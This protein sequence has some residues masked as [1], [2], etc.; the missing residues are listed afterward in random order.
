[1]ITVLATKLH[2]QHEQCRHD[3]CQTLWSF[4]ALISE[5]DTR[6][7]RTLKD[8]P[9]AHSFQMMDSHAR[10]AGL[11]RLHGAVHILRYAYTHLLVGMEAE[12][13]NK[14]SLH[15]Q[16]GVQDAHAAHG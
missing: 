6:T 14:G 5:R 9:S 3:D 15:D 10:I 4:G 16:V 8:R 13:R 2:L 1:M 11:A 7:S 12:A